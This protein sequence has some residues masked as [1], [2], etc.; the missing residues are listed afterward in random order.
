MYDAGDHYNKGRQDIQDEQ[1]KGRVSHFPEQLE[2]GNA[3][4]IIKNTK[5]TDSGTYSCKFPKLQPAQIFYINL[6]IGE[7]FN[8]T[9]N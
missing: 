9:V 6:V 8:K 1:F 3:S 7:W 4:I 5:M 2:F